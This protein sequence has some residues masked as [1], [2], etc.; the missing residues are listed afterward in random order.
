MLAASVADLPEGPGWE[1][2]MKWDGIRALCDVAAGSVRL[3]SRT[4]KDLT[5][6]FPELA[7]VGA[8]LGSHAAALDGEIVV[9]DDAGRPSFEALQVHAQPAALMLFDLLELDGESLL[10]R[11]YSERRARL[12]AL[13]L[14]GSHWQTPPRWTERETAL[15]T[16]ERLGLEGV[17]AKRLD[18][19]YEP[20]R[21]TGAWRKLKLDRNQELVVGGWLPG[22]NRL[23]DRLGSLL[24]GVWD[25]RGG[26]LRYAGRVGSGIREATRADLEARLA[27]L[28]RD[29][30][31]FANPP[32]LRDA[33]W[34]EPELVVDVRFTEWTRAGVLRQPRFRGLRDDKDPRDVVRE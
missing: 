14:Q 34:A 27:G 2:E 25:E 5:G 30:P 18:S 16:A 29:T 22:N 21:R 33:R 1:F 31:P 4:E 3:R 32:R 17:V 13:G 15:A 7:G 11:P 8:A 19:T 26:E 28:A 24:V 6:R 20:G 9:L 10:D 12:E 23:S